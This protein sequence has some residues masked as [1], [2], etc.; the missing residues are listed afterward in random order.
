MHTIIGKQHKTCKSF[1]SHNFQ[2]KRSLEVNGD[3]IEH[4]HYLKEFFT[5]LHVR[6]LYILKCPFK[7]IHIEQHLV[8]T[9]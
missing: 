9:I 2:T 6:C 7:R 1:I 8:Y 3:L 4:C 5:Q